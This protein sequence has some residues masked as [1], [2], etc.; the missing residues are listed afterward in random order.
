MHNISNVFYVI[1]TQRALDLLEEYRT[2]L[3]QTEDKQL[4][5]S[6]ERV[7]GIFQS[8]LFQALIGKFFNYAETSLLS[9][10]TQVLQGLRL[11][12]TFVMLI[13]ALQ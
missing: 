4:R 1:D 8:N 13:G 10:F 5:K 3:N 2:K 7:I 12:G 9:V 11:K 6:I